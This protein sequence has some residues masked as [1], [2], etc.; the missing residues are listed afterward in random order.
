MLL[1][2]A[3]PI[4]PPTCGGMLTAAEAPSRGDEL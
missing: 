4:E 2:S 1:S 3:V